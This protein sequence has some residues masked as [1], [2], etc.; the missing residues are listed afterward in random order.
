MWVVP[1]PAIPSRP[2]PVTHQK[3]TVPRLPFCLNTGTSCAQ[4]P[5]HLPRGEVCVRG[6]TVF[7]G[8]PPPLPT[9]PAKLP[10][11]MFCNHIL[12]TLAPVPP[13][14]PLPSPLSPPLP[15]VRCVCAAPPCSRATSKMRRRHGTFWMTPAGCTRV[16]GV[17]EGGGVW[18]G[19]DS[20]SRRGG[21]CDKGG[22]HL[23][24]TVQL[25]VGEG[26][27]TT[28]VVCVE[29][30]CLC[31]LYGSVTPH[32]P[33]THTHPGGTHTRVTRSHRR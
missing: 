33:A 29:A 9:T 10:P 20:R 2:L 15:G 17:L 11:C 1:W 23:V 21:V 18:E 7:Q 12:N 14:L 26:G 3:C 25:Q 5:P 6:P 13:F 28:L 32:T 31:V 30:A 27:C 8:T 4:L 16:R 19:A 22:M 24:M